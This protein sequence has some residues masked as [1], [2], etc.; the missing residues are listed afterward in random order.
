MTKP[1]LSELE[2]KKQNKILLRFEYPVYEEKKKVLQDRSYV[3]D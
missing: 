1:D 3:L 2:N